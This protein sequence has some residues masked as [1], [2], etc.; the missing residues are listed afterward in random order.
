VKFHD[1]ISKILI[2][3]LANVDFIGSPDMDMPGLASRQG[4]Q[5]QRVGCSHLVNSNRFL[6]MQKR[7][8]ANLHEKTTVT[9]HF[10]GN[11]VSFFFFPMIIG[12]F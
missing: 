10:K 9:C 1:I 11:K 5:A 12:N 7:S 2:G 8:R 3:R 6:V 4:K